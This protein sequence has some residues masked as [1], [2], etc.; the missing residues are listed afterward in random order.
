MTETA[1]M[2]K[3]SNTLSDDSDRGMELD[4]LDADIRRMSVDAMNMLDSITD[5]V[6]GMANTSSR[7]S[8]SRLV[9]PSSHGRQEQ[10]ESFPHTD[11]HDMTRSEKAQPELLVTPSPEKRIKHIDDID[12]GHDD[13]TDYDD[14]ISYDGS[15]DD[16]IMKEMEALNK[17]AAEIERELSAQDVQTMQKAMLELQNSPKATL[18]ERIIDLD[19]REI[20]RKLLEEEMLKVGPKTEWEKFTQRFPSE[21]LSTEQ[22]TY[23]LASSAIVVWSIVVGLIYKSLYRDLI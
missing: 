14:D 3:I 6:N 5:E 15:C 17:V 18:R 13:E 8:K 2:K 1:T 10:L 11:A 20:I 7:K 4:D 12:V 23:I 22:Q 9:S 21:G 16:S 19:D